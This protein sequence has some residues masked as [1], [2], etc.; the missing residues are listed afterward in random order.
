M[1]IG[2]LCDHYGRT[3]DLPESL[4]RLALHRFRL[5]QPLGWPAGA[6]STSRAPGMLLGDHLRWSS[7]CRLPSPR[8]WGPPTFPLRAD[9]TNRFAKMYLTCI[10]CAVDEING[11]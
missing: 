7:T 9:L 4:R 5:A 3:V 8:R 1:V 2:M 6:L 10:F 11:A